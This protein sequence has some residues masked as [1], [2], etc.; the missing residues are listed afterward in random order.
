MIHWYQKLYMDEMVS[1]HPRRCKKQVMQ[2]KPWKKSYFAITLATNP[3]NL[4]EIMETRQ[5]FFRRYSY[6]DLYVVGLTETYENA[7][8]VLQQILLEMEKEEGT[9]STDTYFKKTEFSD[10]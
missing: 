2:R 9:F 1:E 4:F 5:L 8:Q 10:R 7:V 3:N 6:M